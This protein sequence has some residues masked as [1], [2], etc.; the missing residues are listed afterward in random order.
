MPPMTK[1]LAP[2]AAPAALQAATARRRAVPSGVTVVSSRRAQG[3]EAAAAA[4]CRQRPAVS[5]ITDVAVAAVAAPAART[6]RLARIV[7]R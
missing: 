5:A 7:R 2:A 3:T 1:P 4:P 6:T